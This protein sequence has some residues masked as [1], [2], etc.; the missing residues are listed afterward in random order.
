MAV[1]VEYKFYSVTVAY[2]RKKFRSKDPIVSIYYT[3]IRFA[4]GIYNFR[5]NTFSLYSLE[6]H[7]PNFYPDI[8][9]LELF[10][11]YSCISYPTAWWLFLDAILKSNILVKRFC[12]F[13][14]RRLRGGPFP[15]SFR[16]LIRFCMINFPE[17]DRDFPW[18]LVYC[19]KLVSALSNGGVLYEDR[20]VEFDPKRFF[21]ESK[22][23]FEIFENLQHLILK[24]PKVFR[25]ESLKK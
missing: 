17:L 10:S 16:N 2:L 7:L 5:T 22:C 3:G 6:Y 24:L 11:T 19:N 1:K 15:A 13:L 21:V 12:I 23:S 9:N 18:F 14:G 4:E 25:T 20:Q 8:Y